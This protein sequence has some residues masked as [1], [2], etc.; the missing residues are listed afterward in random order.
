MTVEV[1]AGPRWLFSLG[2]GFV[3]NIRRNMLFYSVL[4]SLGSASYV[5]RIT[6]GCK[7][8]NNGTLL[9]GRNAILLNGG[10]GFICFSKRKELL[11]IQGCFR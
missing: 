6:L 8:I 4:Q 11:P 2:M 3:S 1:S 10:K 9:G 7:F 5:A